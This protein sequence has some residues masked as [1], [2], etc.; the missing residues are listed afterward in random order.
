ML[1]AHGG[2]E[3]ELK[4]NRSGSDEDNLGERARSCRA[5]SNWGES[6]PGARRYDR[7]VNDQSQKCLGQ[8]SVKNSDLIL[9]HGH[10]KT[11]KD[12]LQNDSTEGNQTKPSYGGTVI[13]NPKPD[14]ER[15]SQASD[16]RRDQ[17]MGVLKKYS[18]NPA[19][20]RKQK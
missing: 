2:P 20:E 12:T 3:C 15:N 5:I 17:T 7:D 9:Q 14:R 11:T 4:I 1:V 10:A 6:A 19:R 8:E 18:A 13:G 16:Q